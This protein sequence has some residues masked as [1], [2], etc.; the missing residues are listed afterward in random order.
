MTRFTVPLE[1]FA[2]ITR[3]KMDLFGRKM[4]YQLFSAVVRKSPVDTGRFRGNWQIA[5]D[6]I[7]VSVLDRLDPSGSGAL[8]VAAQALSIPLGGVVYL[9]NN[10]PY[11]RRLEYGYSQQ[12]PLGMVRTSIAEQ[13]AGIQKAFS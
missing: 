3:E 1:R 10:L 9:A 7:P 6:T 8:I 4:T 5:R 2:N 13:Q 12:A 11:A